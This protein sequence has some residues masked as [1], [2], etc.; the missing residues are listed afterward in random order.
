MCLCLHK[1]AAKFWVA[2]TKKLRQGGGAESSAYRLREA[3]TLLK[4]LHIGLRH[5]GGPP[6]SAVYNFALK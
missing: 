5:L 4:A 3:K 1:V 2:P 6:L